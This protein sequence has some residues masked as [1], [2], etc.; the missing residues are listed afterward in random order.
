M[1]VV[2]HVCIGVCTRDCVVALLYPMSGTWIE[3]INFG[4]KQWDSDVVTGTEV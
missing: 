1:S 2:K 4:S 3:M